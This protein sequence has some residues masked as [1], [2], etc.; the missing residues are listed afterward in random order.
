MNIALRLLRTALFAAIV[1]P[2][3]RLAHAQ[4]RPN[5]L[6]MFSDDHAFQAISAY[7]G[8]LADVA[9]TPQI[10]RIAEEGIRF[11][12]AYVTNSICAPSRA[13]VLTGKYSHLNGVIDNAVPFDGS[14][15]T[16][17]KLLRDA[18]Y[19]TAFIGKWHLK[20]EPT[21]FNYSDRMP[22]QGFYYNPWFIKD[23]DTTR[24]DGYVTDIITDK[25]IDWLKERNSDRPF[26]LMMQHKAPHREWAPPLEYLT[27]F[28]DIDIPEPETLFDDYSGRGTAAHEQDMTL[29]KSMFMDLDLKIPSDEWE[30]KWFKPA[31]ERMT[32]EQRAVWDAA[33]GPKNEA[34]FADRPEG[35]EFI[36]WKYQRYLKDYLRC[37]RSVDDSI[38]EVLDYLDQAGL[39][40]NT[41]V[42]YTSDQGFYLGEHGWFDKRF[43]YEES[44]RT[45]LVARWPGVVAPGRVD[46]HLV[47]NVDFAQ[48]LLDVAGVEEPADM[49]GLSL[50]SIL[51]GDEAPRWRE[52][53]Y[54]HYYEFP[55]W[56]SVR[57]HEGVFDGRYKLI[58]FYELGEWEFF[59]L[60]TD[61]RELTSRYGD[62]HLA[63]E[64]ERM[65]AELK[66]QRQV[67][68]VPD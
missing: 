4:D 53:L 59:D 45:P 63:V 6:F 41:L 65:R 56:H 42:I 60:K 64:V 9:P 47:A 49:Q 36:R 50:V 58:H 39:S 16:F 37:I 38:G 17:P 35:R 48:T 28:D 30:S 18:G 67:L 20:S 52:S 24:V 66:R 62:P 15:Q 46:S 33:Y 10:D 13:V 14:Q 27:L 54:Y 44:F 26:M 29:D 19:E 55:G 25:A 34:F 68:Q 8:R 22:G 31:M 61:P 11:D 5:I 3:P 23:G 43:M 57:K 7:G 21:G 32:S 12:R 40:E 2:A 1:W 51:K